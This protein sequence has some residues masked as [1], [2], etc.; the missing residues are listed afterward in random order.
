MSASE[1]IRSVSKKFI[2]ARDAGELLFFPST[3]WKHEEMGMEF[4]IKL[5]PAL[6]KKHAIE[7]TAKADGKAPVDALAPPYNPSLHVGDLQDEDGTKYAVL[8]NKFSLVPDHFLLVTE[9]FQSQASPLM[10]VD[11]KQ[12]YLLLVAA[13][14]AGKRYFAF[15]NC[16][17]YSGASQPRKHIQFIPVEDYDSPPIE[18]LAR[19]ANLEIP[20]RASD[21]PFS[22]TRLS[23]ANHV[24]RLPTQLSSSTPDKIEEKLSTVFLSLL[25]LAVS[26]IR[27]NP[28]Y[29]PGKPSYNVLITLEHIHLV[30]R[31]QDV[32]VIPES[33]MKVNINALGFAGMLLVKSEEELEALKKESVGKI[34]R[35]VGLGSVHDIQVADTALEAED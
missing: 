13:R 24:F 3:T 21:K 14:K 15:Y 25:D 34:L 26:T 9:A 22:L 32:Y 16:G 2:E 5:C 28:D 35:S 30:P 10:P 18:P 17:D 12:A 31:K 27:H 1:I 29:P 4:E 11:L 23:Y 8:L 19:A 7:S 20:G 6:Q 33:E